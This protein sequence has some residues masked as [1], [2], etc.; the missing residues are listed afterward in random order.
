MVEEHGQLFRERKVMAF[1]ST[2]KVPDSRGNELH[3]VRAAV[4]RAGRRG[5]T[6]Y[7]VVQVELLRKHEFERRRRSSTVSGLGHRRWPGA[8]VAFRATGLYPRRR[9]W[10]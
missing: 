8:G 2:G 1:G 4:R 9:R 3:D 5:S 10:P 7:V 6:P